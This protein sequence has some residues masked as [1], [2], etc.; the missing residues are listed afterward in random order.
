MSSTTLAW[1]REHRLGPGHSTL[2][3]GNAQN[4]PA[5]GYLLEKHSCLAEI[6]LLTQLPPPSPMAP[7]ENWQKC[8]RPPQLA[9]MFCP[10]LRGVTVTCENTSSED[11]MPGFEN[12]L[13]D[14]GK[15]TSLSVQQLSICN[16]G[17]RKM[18]ASRTALRIRGCAP[19]AH[20]C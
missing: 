19:R 13:Y 17:V 8:P 20:E 16:P 6:I 2:P 18:P 3:P 1:D 9:G 7:Q 11:Q 12:W 5:C 4:G 15:S 10:L 14:P